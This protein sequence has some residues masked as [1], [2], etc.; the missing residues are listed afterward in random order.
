MWTHDLRQAMRLFRREPGLA[1]TALLTLALGIG[2][3][4]ALFTVIQAVLLTRCPSTTRAASS[5]CGTGT[6]EPD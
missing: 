1:A 4:T 6:C 5:S 3:N 2:A